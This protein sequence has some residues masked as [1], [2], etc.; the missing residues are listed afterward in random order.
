MG[1]LSLGF[2]RKST[3]FN[4]PPAGDVP[5]SPSFRVMERPGASTP[6]QM[7]APGMTSAGPRSPVKRKPVEGDDN[8]FAGMTN[9]R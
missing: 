5:P 7:H 8:M 1:R 6:S 3:A 4:D 2:R 9:Y